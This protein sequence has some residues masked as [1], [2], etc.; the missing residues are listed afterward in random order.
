MVGHAISKPGAQH[1]HECL[2]GFT[3]S[4]QNYKT[5]S[6]YLNK[7]ISASQQSLY[8]FRS[9]PLNGNLKK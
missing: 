3:H 6:N 2:S 9:Y 7:N 5:S 4:G 8:T 1:T